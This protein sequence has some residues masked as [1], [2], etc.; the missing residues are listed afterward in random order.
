MHIRTPLAVLIACLAFNGQFT[1]A[2]DPTAGTSS[3]PPTVKDP[4]KV[5][6]S[7]YD[8]SADAKAQIAAALAKA[9]VEN[10]RVLIQW[11][12]NWC[13]WCIRLHELYKTDAKIKREL[14]YE[15]DVV[16]VD[17]GKKGKNMDLAKSYNASAD[18][19][20]FPYLTILDADGRVI[21]N[22]ESGS[23][24]VKNVEGKSSGLAAG[25]DPALVLK[26]LKDH[27][28]TYLNAT[29]VLD[30][31]L[32]EAK[33][34]GRAVFLHFGAPWCPYCHKLD[35]W[36]RR[37]DIAPVLAKNFVD[38]KIDVDRMTGG[39]EV[40]AKY[41][42]KHEKSGIPWFVFLDSTGKP[43]AD[44]FTEKGENVG[45]PTDP[46]EVEHFGVMLR[47]A[48]KKM[49]ASDVEMLVKSLNEPKK[50]GNTLVPL[51]K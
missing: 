17:A 18:K 42:G 5:V 45:F 33:A 50:A 43:I 26:F 29:E 7:I 10:R 41:N 46:T 51:G 37:A 15:Y 36:M 49:A 21:A 20:G 12:G 14:L 48:A 27:Q 44:S 11:G 4:A 35:N 3:S 47:K 22:Q 1:L 23:L 30:R 31:A 40:L 13:P 9:K 6:P 25:H 24:E 28:A 16:F 32:G 2:D 19:E 34:S 38:V 8:E 39:K